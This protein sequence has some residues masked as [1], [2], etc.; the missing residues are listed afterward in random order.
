MN[1]NK[2][3]KCPF[4][5]V[6]DTKEK[7]INHID[8]K[9]TDMI[10][11]GF[12][13]ARVL[14]HSIHKRPYN[15]KGTCVI[16]KG[17]TEWNEKTYKYNRLCNRRE[18]K[19]K[20]RDSYK[21]NMLKV[22]G[23]YNILNDMNQQEKMLRNRSISGVYTFRNGK[24]KQ[25]VGSYEKK[26]LEFCDLMLNMDPDDI[27]MPGPT[28][29]YEYRG[30]KHVWITDAMIIPYNL[31]IDVKDGGDFKNNREMV[32]Y[33]EKQIEKEKVITNKG[34]YN[35]L[36]LTNNE[37][38]Q[39]IGIIYELKMQMIDDPETTKTI[40]RVHEST[41]YELAKKVY[42]NLSDDEKILVSPRGKFIDSPYKIY[43][44]IEKINNKPIGFIDAYKYNGISDTVAFVIL[45]VSSQYRGK[46]I[47][48]K[49][50]TNCCIK[51]KEMGYKKVIYRLDKENK[52]SFNLINN[53]EGSKKTNET[54]TQLSFEIPL[55][56]SVEK[57]CYHKPRKV[58]SNG[59][60]KDALNVC[61][62]LTKEDKKFFSF[63]TSGESINTIY[64]YFHYIDNEPVGFVELSMTCKGEK[65]L[66]PLKDGVWIGIVVDPEHRGQGISKLLLN[67]AIQWFN[68]QSEFNALCY[69][70]DRDN[71][72]SLGLIK[73]RHDFKIYEPTKNYTRDTYYKTKKGAEIM[74]ESSQPL[75]ISEKDVEYRVD[76]F[77]NHKVA[78]LWITGQSGSGK[79]TSSKKLADEYKCDRI[80]ID[81]IEHFLHMLAES[82][83]H[84][85]IN[86]VINQDKNF[87]LIY[88]SFG[89]NKQLIEDVTI[90]RGWSNKEWE[91]HYKKLFLWIYKIVKFI[92]PRFT[93]SNQVI[94]E[95]VQIPQIYFKDKSLFKNSAIIVKGTSTITSL[96]RRLK[97]DNP[98]F[99]SIKDIPGTLDNIFGYLKMYKDWHKDISDFRNNGPIKESLILDGYTSSQQS[100]EYTCGPTA[101]IDVYRYYTGKNPGSELKIADQM[102]TDIK[103]GTSI[104]SIT[105]W[106][107]SKGF[108]VEN[109]LEEQERV[110]SYKSFL[111]FVDKYLSAGIPIMVESHYLGGHWRVIV[112]YDKEN[113][114]LRLADSYD[115]IDGNHDGYTLSP[116]QEFY[117]NWHD[118]DCLPEEE[119]TR[120]WIIV[121]PKESIT[122]SVKIPEIK[123]EDIQ[124][125]KGYDGTNNAYIT[126]KGD[127]YRVRVETLIVNDKG[128]VYI[129]KSDKYAKY[130]IQYRIPGGS[131]EPDRDFITQAENE[132]KEEVH[133]NIKNAY[134]SGQ[135]WVML[136][137]PNS[138]SGI[139]NFRYKGCISYIYVAE[140]NGKY[141]GYVK[142]ADRDDMYKTGK[143]YK[144]KD[145]KWLPEH[146]KALEDYFKSHKVLKESSNTMEDIIRTSKDKEYDKYLKI[147][148][149]R[150]FAAYNDRVYALKNALL[151]SVE[152]VK[153]LR[154]RILVHDA[155]RYSPE[156]WDGLRK[157]YFPND[158]KERKE[159]EESEKKARA[160]HYKVN[161]HH[162]EHWNG[163]EMDKVSIAE[164]IIDWEADS[165]ADGGNPLKWWLYND[166]AKEKKKLLNPKTREEV[167]RVLQTIYDV[168]MNLKD[169]FDRIDDPKKA[170]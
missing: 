72:A 128:E 100:T 30:E 153:E 146:K 13:A 148:K 61:K 91:D 80:G 16:C 49:M 65:V 160:H 22:Y 122:E 45:A 18:C 157:S 168:D 119:K 82:D 106:F 83:K 149:Q 151:L 42:D 161:A 98:T 99:G 134:Y 53:Y 121:K 8:K 48:K 23:T 73:S 62:K 54:K 38:D 110:Y 116:T 19:D 15:I 167:E 140:Y 139:S 102:N 51:L 111:R 131:V 90:K 47:A 123:P 164:M 104:K 44:Y 159:A 117:D 103:V 7:L 60:Y 170:E 127:N 21:K 118:K 152:E 77:K 27:M 94:I 81:D 141:H 34:E 155:S 63:G 31:V 109:S 3:F 143:F 87:E 130:G 163:K 50:L 129:D 156:E 84:K 24:I 29:E 125:I 162:P 17:E 142:V 74:I 165:K 166:E 14:F 85:E 86:T 12:S 79:S 57:Q 1:P 5:S 37:F 147:H 133:I 115:R 137:P 67:K 55:N 2:R 113:D 95:G 138:N 120:P 43:R 114:I 145:I 36:R 20:L 124:F 71:K 40:S 32:S 70:V 76:D 4:C 150:L 144:Y 66:E 56:E 52:G 97:R 59:T 136:F 35:Y 101:A 33:R 105:E 64:R 108:I 112:G 75:F 89:K 11:E 78:I 158:D 88:N 68:G 28:I 126:Y 92:V 26:F 41:D 25:F 132:C 169:N 6:H 10:P 46:G 9:H 58:E 107:R 154:D 93:N 135:N 96:T 39:L 69:S